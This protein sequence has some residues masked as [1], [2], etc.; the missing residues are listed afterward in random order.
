MVDYVRVL[1]EQADRQA[2]RRLP[3][4]RRDIGEPGQC[5][6]EVVVRLET[7]YR[8]GA[9]GYSRIQDPEERKADYR[10]D[11]H[12]NGKGGNV[13]DDFEGTPRQGR[14]FKEVLLGGIYVPSRF[15]GFQCDD[16]CAGERLNLLKYI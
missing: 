13:A 2:H 6:D 15:V 8:L 16:V 7:A 3:Q 1:E 9:G 5:R 14:G 11:L 12:K 10:G 4:C